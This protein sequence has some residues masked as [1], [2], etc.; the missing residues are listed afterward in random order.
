[1]ELRTL[2]CC[3]AIALL[4]A[5]AGDARA[6]GSGQGEAVSV[7]ATVGSG[8]G[9][10][11]DTGAI[12]SG[13]A[14]T[15]PLDFEIVADALDANVTLGSLASVSTG[16]L[17]AG[18]RA[19]LGREHAEATAGA[20]SLTI[21]IGGPLGVV[22]TLDGAAA[23]ALI[24]CREGQAAPALDAVLEGAQLR[25]AG[26][27]IALAADAAPNTAVPLP[28]AGAQLVLNRQVQANGVA[29]VT[30][31]HLLLDDAVV[32]TAPVPTLVDADVVVAR[33]SAGLAACGS[34]VDGDGDGLLDS[35]DNCPASANPSQRDT[36]GDG[37][38]DACDVDDDA[39]LVIDA[40]DTCPLEANPAQGAC[41]DA[42]FGDGF[43]G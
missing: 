12:P 43:E 20:Q 7:R 29:S 16:R 11:L 3:A 25:I 1:M 21:E 33:A 6:A 37:A 38:G 28:L 32:G 24:A 8:G 17:R 31:L 14:A 26:D 10:A 23:T 41:P 36:D 2:G 15:A 39:D 34:F 42:V 27:P 4:L 35:V 19:L 9:S 30:A 22:L 40:T 5:T 13:A 18:V